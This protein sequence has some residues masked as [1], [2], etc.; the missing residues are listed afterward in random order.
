MKQMMRVVAVIAVVSLSMG[1][2]S[3]SGVGQSQSPAAAMNENTIAVAKALFSGKTAADALVF[4]RD[5]SQPLVKEITTKADANGNYT[6]D[7][8][9]LK[10]PFALKSVFS[11]GSTAYAVATAPG[12]VD[13]NRQSSTLVR[14]AAVGLDIAAI[15]WTIGGD[16]LLII[17]RA[18]EGLSQAIS[19]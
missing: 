9:G 8:T 17:A 7:A 4:L 18:A 14:L 5:S 15:I 19:N 11:N 2:G 13:I 12:A 1:C 16:I 6:L 10:A 3:G